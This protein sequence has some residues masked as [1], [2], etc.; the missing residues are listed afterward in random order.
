MAEVLSFLAR[1]LNEV[2]G[3]PI[4]R[5]VTEWNGTADFLD[6]FLFTASQQPNQKREI[7]L[8]ND[9][10]HAT[11]FVDLLILEAPRPLFKGHLKMFI[12]TNSSYTSSNSSR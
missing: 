10:H 12:L 2:F 11:R 5:N 7:K 3:F 8:S 9:K 6:I 4:L 1:A